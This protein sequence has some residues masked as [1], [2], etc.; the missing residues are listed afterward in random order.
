MRHAAAG[1]TYISTDYVFDGQGTAGATTKRRPADPLNHYGLTKARGEEAGGRCRPWQ[2]VRTSWLFGDGRVNFVKTIRR[3]LGE[4][5]TLQVVDDQRGCPTYAPDLAECSDSLSSAWHH[6]IFHG[7]KRGLHLVRVRPGDR[8]LHW[9]RSGAHPA[10][11]QRCLSD[12]RRRG[13]PARCCAAGA[14]KRWA[15]RRGPTWQDALA[16]YLALLDVGPRPR[17]PLMPPSG[18][19]E[20]NDGH[21]SRPARRTRR[22]PLFD[23]AVER[24]AARPSTGWTSPTATP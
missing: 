11:R 23:A 18:K 4:R 6:G 2:I 7:T 21:G 9:T 8:P 17:L 20:P 13:R 15:A 3:L 22:R 24:T 1:L 12:G 16:R 10:L 19:D 5:E 14:W